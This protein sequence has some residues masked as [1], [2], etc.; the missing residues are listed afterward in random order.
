M[1]EIKKEILEISN[2]QNGLKSCETDGPKN[3]NIEFEIISNR[4]PDKQI[5]YFSIHPKYSAKGKFENKA[6]NISA[7]FHNQPCNKNW[8][9]YYR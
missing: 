8:S 6:C 9:Q 7:P 2:I 3:E 5:D 1:L 4:N